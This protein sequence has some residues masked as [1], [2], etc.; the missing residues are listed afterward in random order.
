MQRTKPTEM[1]I[2]FTIEKTEL[3]KYTVTY[4][5]YRGKWLCVSLSVDLGISCPTQTNLAPDERSPTQCRP[6]LAPDG[7]SSGSIWPQTA[8]IWGRHVIWP[9][10]SH[11][12]PRWWPQMTAPDINLGNHL[13]LFRP[14][15]CSHAEISIDHHHHISVIIIWPEHLTPCQAITSCLWQPIPLFS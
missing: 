15:C 9:Q 12:G 4:F 1:S 10:M 14:V 8:F 3:Y 11:L 5:I 7:F 2:G 13:G 6:D